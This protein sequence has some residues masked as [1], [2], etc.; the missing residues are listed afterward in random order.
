MEIDL[1]IRNAH[2]D[3]IR[4]LL[5]NVLV[6]A[7]EFPGLE[8][9]KVPVK[10][11]PA[12]P[13]KKPRT[14][15]PAGGWKIPFSSVTDKKQYEHAWKL[16]HNTGK[17]YPDAIKTTL[18]SKKTESSPAVQE[19]PPK[20][21]GSEGLEEILPEARP[22]THAEQ[23]KAGKITR[24]KPGIQTDADPADSTQ[25]A[26]AAVMDPL[27]VGVKVRE[28]GVKKTHAGIGTIKRAPQMGEERMVE[29][30]HGTAWISK[31][32]L[33]PVVASV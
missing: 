6:N 16:C 31:K 3:E 23:K 12:A 1:T 13:E 32:C 8:T 27:G 33:E 25:P 11:V 21:I 24:L 30:E 20:I 5:R 18:Q 14:K 17:S 19:V 9:P 22:P 7:N 28:I 15:P 26:A 10:K 2:A 4:D 29:F